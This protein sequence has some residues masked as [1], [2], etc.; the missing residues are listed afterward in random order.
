MKK[1]F[2]LFLFAVVGITLQAQMIKN[3]IPSVEKKLTYY[4]INYYPLSKG[5]SIK[6]ENQYL[7]C[8]FWNDNFF[9]GINSNGKVSYSTKIELPKDYYFVKAFET[10]KDIVGIYA[11]YNKGTAAFYINKYNK[12]QP[13]WKPKKINSYPS[14]EKKDHFIYFTAVS[15]DNTKFCIATVLADKKDNFKGMDV[16]AYDEN[17]EKIWQNNINPDVSGETFAVNDI[18]LT[19]AGDAYICVST[20]S[21]KKSKSNDEKLYL[22]EIKEGSFT[23]YNPGKS[24][25]Y[26]DGTKIKLLKN[27][28]IF[29]AGYYCEKRY[30][31]CKGSFS[32]MFDTKAQTI[33]NFSFKEFATILKKKDYQEL[34]FDQI[35]ELSN[36]NIVSL[37]EQRRRLDLSNR[38]S[39]SYTYFAN[40]IICTSFSS[41][42]MIENLNVIYKRQNYISGIYTNDYKI[43]CL[44]YYAFEKNGSLYLL[45]NDH[46]EN[47]PNDESVKPIIPFFAKNNVVRLLKID[48]DTF[49]SQG[50]IFGKTSKSCLHALLFVNDNNLIISSVG[51][52]VTVD[53]ITVTF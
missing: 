15:P 34:Y 17:G 12:R 21:E 31:Q 29:I 39:K 42:G 24:I 28:N 51:K 50:L 10:E 49:T 11:F 48:G 30:E 47:N 44:S 14:F 38:D 43:F 18:V 33:S 32:M 16:I 9:Y 19:D 53:K 8:S 2:L 4:Y 3:L 46:V 7:F 20:F 23:S 25:G 41:D 36:G 26:I 5:D 45:Y 13:S 35:I 22:Y 27:G 6:D 52:A 37:G 40:N 1:F